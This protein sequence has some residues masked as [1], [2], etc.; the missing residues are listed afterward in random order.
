MSQ[1]ESN[2]ATLLLS[3]QLDDEE[4]G[5]EEANARKAIMVCERVCA[6]WGESDGSQGGR[7]NEGHV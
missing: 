1:L 6:G 3:N 5:N 7:I 2:R 4:E